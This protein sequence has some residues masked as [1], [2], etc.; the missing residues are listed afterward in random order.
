MIEDVVDN[1]GENEDKDDEFIISMTLYIPGYDT[2]HIWV[3]NNSLH[4]VGFSA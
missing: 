2:L 3:V 4:G 1:P